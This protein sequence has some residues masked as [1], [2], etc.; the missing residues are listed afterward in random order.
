MNG[1]VAKYQ[2]G[3]DEEFDVVVV[4]FGCAGACAAIEAAD[5]GGSV[6]VIDRFAGGGATKR[7]G[8]VIYAGGGSAAQR[9]AGF[10]DSAA[11]MRRYLE[12]ETMGSV[13]SRTLA[14]FC[15]TSLENLRWLEKLGVVFPEA[16]YMKKTTQPPGGYGLYFSGNER[17]FAKGDPPVPRGHLPLSYGMSG[18]ALFDALEK[19]VLDR[20][21]SVRCRCRSERLILDERGAVTGIEI[22]SLPDNVTVRFFHN[23]FFYLGFA[24]RGLA[25]LLN[26]FEKGLGKKTRVRA[27]GGVVI[28]AGGFVFNRAMM[29]E[30]ASEYKRCMPLGTP[31]DDGS[32]IRLGL[33]AGGE[34]RELGSCAASRFYCPPE[35]FASG[36]LV[37][38]EGRRFCDE[39]LYGATISR[40]I[41]R[42]AEGRAYLVIDSAVY[43][44]AGE[45]MKQED[46]L[47]TSPLRKVVSGELNALIFRKAMA[48]V[49]M[50]LNR[51]K[52][53]SISDLEKKCGMPAG[54]LLRS[55]EEHN[56]RI[57]RRMSD[58]FGKPEQY[59]GMLAE[60]PFYA[61]DCRLE[62]RLFPSPCITLGGLRVD[63][64][65][66]QVLRVDGSPVSGLFAAGRSAAGVCSRSYVS[67]LSLADSIF[68]GR[69]AGRGA[70]RAAGKKRPGGKN[71]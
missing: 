24:F 66:A 21:V 40:Q 70:A 30:H 50:H 27:R 20:G 26:F 51:I 67:G 58:E 54:S 25:P 36:M 37:N 3:W 34:A 38:R 55:I 5:A 47:L 7:S 16:Y 64:E 65:H 31:A 42:Q 32:G 22:L 44:M 53:R 9:S 60:P 56:R 48:F 45:Q 1:G 69:R 29:E 68:S 71:S 61:I 46:R 57:T 6:L 11:M 41:S 39:S 10:R 63:R 12:S 4:G 14:D 8:G 59:R 28:C 13:D 19:G 35:A 2:G 33:S 18:G 43:T 49:N 15:R 23:L 52:A 62:S 17:Q